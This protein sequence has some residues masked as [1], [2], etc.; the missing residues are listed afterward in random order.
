MTVDW[1]RDV[2]AHVKIATRSRA[3]SIISIADP[4]PPRKQ[5]L[6]CVSDLSISDQDPS[7]S[8][9]EFV[10]N[11]SR[12]RFSSCSTTGFS[13]QSLS[14]QWN[15]FSVSTDVK[16]GTT[17]CLIVGAQT[18][19]QS[20][21]SRCSSRRNQKRATIS[22][23][24]LVCKR[25]VG[26]YTG[27][28]NRPRGWK[29]RRT[30]TPVT[31]Q[32]PSM[33]L[34]IRKW[35]GNLRSSVQWDC[36]RRDPELWHPEGDCLI[37]LHAA[38]Q[39][40]RGPS[41]RVPL[42]AIVAA[43]CQPLLERFLVQKRSESPR[44][45]PSRHRVSSSH[46]EHSRTIELYIPAPYSTERGDAYIHHMATRNF[47]AW[48]CGKS[49]VGP[50]LGS[51][52]VELLM[53]MEEWRNEGQDNIHDIMTYMD[54][55][56]YSDINSQPDHALAI[57]YFAEHFRFRD[58][59]I[60]AFAHC[61]GMYDSLVFST[62]YEFISRVSRALISRSKIE[63]DNRLDQCGRKLS[64][65]LHEELAYTMR[66][67]S[68]DAKAHL[69]RFRTFL[70]SFYV[71]KVGYYP[72]ISPNSN[73]DAFPKNV[74]ELMVTDFAQLYEYL[75]DPRSL[76][77]APE[78]TNA[79]TD[80]LRNVTV[81]DARHKHTR[82][83]HA[84]PMLPSMDEYTP[85]KAARRLGWMPAKVD[86]LRPDHRMVAFSALNRATN[87]T[88]PALYENSLVR[89]YRV[90]EKETIY[91]STKNDPIE[92]LSPTEGR[93]VRWVAIYAIYQTLIAA[94]KV[95]KEVRDPDHVPYLLCVQSAGCPPWKETSVAA[96][97][98]TT[99]STNNSRRRPRLEPETSQRK[100]SLASHIIYQSLAGKEVDPVAVVVKRSSLGRRLSVVSKQ[101]TPTIGQRN[102]PR[103]NSVVQIST[104]IQPPTSRAMSVSRLPTQTARRLSIRE[105]LVSR[106]VMPELVHPRPRRATYHE[107]L[108]SDYGNGIQDTETLSKRASVPLS[109]GEEDEPTKRVS[110]ITQ[111]PLSLAY[112]PEWSER[113]EQGDQQT[114]RTFSFDS[115]YSMSGPDTSRWSTSENG[116]FP[117]SPATTM[118][119]ASGSRRSSNA[120]DKTAAGI[121]EILGQV[122]INALGL[123]RLSVSSSIYSEEPHYVEQKAL[124]P[125]PLRV[126]SIH[127]NEYPSVMKQMRTDWSSEIAETQE[128]LLTYLSSN[129]V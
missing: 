11:R 125:H 90:Y 103:V 60:D 45:D 48:I 117:G 76:P 12:A 121:E 66:G 94:T 56:G 73:T 42:D 58:M 71:T 9:A 24:T 102:P 75:A 62:G 72:P 74:F 15:Y 68:S 40:R 59:Y 19:R 111:K 1:F 118:S 115:D 88:N 3:S 34:N 120:G 6:P 53:S 114:A 16:L 41:F 110:F 47:F 80:V 65:F 44:S 106:A 96:T 99:N 82:L 128:E 4:I 54:E 29:Q 20:P 57:L 10:Q 70:H 49:L 32:S 126:K 78:A 116:D 101:S 52:L 13:G 127:E 83:P 92:K 31:I 113:V 39:S 26:L 112:I 89:S 124:R 97:A 122:P 8:P 86:K 35:N 93:K 98:A 95:P 100:P 51:A 84:M 5:A 23:E 7:N 18:R 2:T 69:E 30:S 119:S 123:R 77:S 17:N 46:G 21:L 61:V 33:E 37:Y 50:Q 81:F 67:L 27:L 85:T 63:M 14:D 36:L 87:C 107:I 109:I 105:A 38:G 25:N 91:P 79:D 43:N 129:L 104:P 55:E 64:S 22:P 28:S 108:V